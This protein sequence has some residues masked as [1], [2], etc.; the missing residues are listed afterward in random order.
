MSYEKVYYC[1]DSQDFEVVCHPTTVVRGSGFSYGL[2]DG[3]Y[4]KSKSGRGKKS[5]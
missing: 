3:L 5:Q 1:K 2:L 4:V